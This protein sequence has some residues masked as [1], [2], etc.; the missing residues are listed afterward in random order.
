MK[1]FL[2]ALAVASGLAVVPSRAQAETLAAFLGGTDIVVGDKT[3][4][5][6]AGSLIIT[7]GSFPGVGGVTPAPPPVPTDIMVNADLTNPTEPGIEITSAQLNVNTGQ[8]LDVK[9]EYTVTVNGTAQIIDNVLSIAGGILPLTGGASIH[10]TE[11][12]VDANNV[13][14]ADKLAAIF[15][16]VNGT[17]VQAMYGPV[18]FVHVTKDISLVGGTTANPGSASLSDIKQNFSETG[19]VP[20]PSTIAM[21]LAGVP[22]LVVVWAR[23]RRKV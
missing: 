5:G 21:A 2:L 1:R 19:A 10:V 18:S 6:I 12:A 7:P 22:V 20:E 13:G 11:T 9:F 23:R 14:L 16:G 8:S 17:F 3:F 15:N 4:H